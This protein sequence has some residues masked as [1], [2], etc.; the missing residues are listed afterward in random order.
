MAS[1]PQAELLTL[2]WPRELR[3][4]I[5]PRYEAVRHTAPGV[6]IVGARISENRPQCLSENHGGGQEL[7]GVLPVATCSS[8]LWLEAVLITALSS[9]PYSPAISCQYSAGAPYWHCGGGDF[10]Y[11]GGGRKCGGVGG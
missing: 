6:S 10:V 3:V 1:I 8:L 5:I 7:W 11:T 9:L 4:L 2:S